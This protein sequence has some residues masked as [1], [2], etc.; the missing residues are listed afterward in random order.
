MWDRKMII[1]GIA[2]T[3]AAVGQIIAAIIFY[4]Y[5]DNAALTNLGWAVMAISGIFGWLPIFTFRR[6]GGVAKGESYMQTT[7]LVDTGIYGIVRHPQYLAG[8]ILS[9]A[10][11]LIAPHWIVIGLGAIAIVINVLNT[12]EEERGCIEKFG[13]AYRDYRD[14]VPRLNPVVGLARWLQRSA[15]G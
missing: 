6:R 1:W 2:L 4:N 8:I 5:T 3:V 9:I 10:L 7:Q 14:R 12:F 13:D 15:H 11:A